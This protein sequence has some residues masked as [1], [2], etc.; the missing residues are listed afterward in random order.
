MS[1]KAELPINR[2]ETFR[3]AIKGQLV[4]LEYCP[5]WACA[6]VYSQRI[7]PIVIAAWRNGGSDKVDAEDLLDYLEEVSAMD[8]VGVILKWLDSEPPVEEPA[9][10]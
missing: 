8:A 2:R 10:A 5:S 7:H 9:N 1:N 6:E 4:W 3:Q